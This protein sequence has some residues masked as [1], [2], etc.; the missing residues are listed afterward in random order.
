MIKIDYVITEIVE[1]N[2]EIKEVIMYKF[3]KRELDYK[4]WK[5]I[6]EDLPIGKS[7][8]INLINKGFLIY[9]AYYNAEEFNIGSKIL[10]TNDNKYIRT[11]SIQKDG[12]YLEHLSKNA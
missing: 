3:E 1:E 10:V 5:L 7:K 4:K 2:N 8:V 12:D 11:D 9:T 6:Q